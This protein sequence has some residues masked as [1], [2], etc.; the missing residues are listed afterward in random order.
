MT[1]RTQLARFIA[2]F[3]PGV[4]RLAR[5]VLGRM[6][7]KM[8]TANLLVYDNYN[9][10]AI[11]FSANER[12]YDS[13]F[14]IAVFPRG[15]SLFFFYGVDLPD[16]LKLL[17]GSGNMG[18]HIRLESPSSLEVPGVRT[19]MRVALKRA[20]PPLPKKGRGRIVIKSIS[21]KQRPRRLA[22]RRA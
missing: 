9:A 12:A 18:R 1:P 3:N 14:S 13:V 20:D 22:A 6:R 21:K 15:V 17:T 7:A 8:P 10:L 5:A 11:G 4:A 2:K 19:L 16:P